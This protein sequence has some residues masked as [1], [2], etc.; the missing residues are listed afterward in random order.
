MFKKTGTVET[1]ASDA[2]TVKETLSHHRADFIGG[3]RM[4]LTKEGSGGGGISVVS[5]DYAPVEVGNIQP[6]NYL[7][8]F[9]GKNFDPVKFELVVASHRRIH[10]VFYPGLAELS[11]D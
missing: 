10:V 9:R 11:G 6:G 1:P 7:V 2:D 5:E 8:T 3:V 4:T